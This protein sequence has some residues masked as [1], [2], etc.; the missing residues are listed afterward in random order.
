MVADSATYVETFKKQF[1]GET[2]TYITAAGTAGA[3]VLQ[4]A[5]EKAG[6]VDPVKVREAM[7]TLDT[8]TFFGPVKFNDAGVDEKATAVVAQV[9]GGKAVVVYPKDIASAPVQYPR[10][11]FQ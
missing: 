2:P 5:I 11:P 8:T 9:Q 1:N 4:L 10:K 6:S 7:L 3:L